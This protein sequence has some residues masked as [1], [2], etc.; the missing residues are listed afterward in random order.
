MAEAVRRTNEERSRRSEYERDFHA[1]AMEQAAH[2]R[3]RRFD[4]LDVD[5][6]VEELETLDR[7][8]RRAIVSRLEVP[9]LHLLTW[10][11]QPNQRSRSWRLS[12]AG[13]RHKVAER[14]DESPSLVPE[15]AELRSKAFESARLQAARETKLALATFPQTCPYTIGQV[16]DPDFLPG[17]AEPVVS[18]L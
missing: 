16:L 9:L 13:Q 15:C 12:I 18:D 10:R 1:W 8:E 3:A 11:F 14:F 5:N 2:V 7:S 17:P 4:R 6:V